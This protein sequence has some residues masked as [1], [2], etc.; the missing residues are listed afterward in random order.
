M[1]AKYE[2][3]S[4]NLSIRSRGRHSLMV[5]RNTFTVVYA[6]SSP[7]GDTHA[8][9]KWNAH[10]ARCHSAPIRTFS[11]VGKSNA[12]IMR[13]SGVQFPDGAQL[14]WYGQHPVLR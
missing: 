8:E 4:S 14:S 7:V 1:L 12:L 10:L 11:S 2:A 9:F 13:R 6:G 5:E 3:E